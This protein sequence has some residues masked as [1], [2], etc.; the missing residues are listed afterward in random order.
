V[1]NSMAIPQKVKTDLPH[2]VAILLLGISSQKTRK[3]VFIQKLMFIAALLFIT[4]KKEKQPQMF[5]NWW[6]DKQNTVY[7]HNEILLVHKKEWSTDT[8]YNMDKPWKH[9]AKWKKPDTKGHTF[10]D[11]LYMWCLRIGD[12]TETESRLVVVRGWEE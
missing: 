4:T 2:N 10:Y 8:W 3:P 11:S 5:K 1:K 6:M 9:D 12:S 7:P